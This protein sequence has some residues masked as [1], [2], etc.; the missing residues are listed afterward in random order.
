MPS[1]SSIPQYQYLGT[2]LSIFIPICLL[3]S[4][5]GGYFITNF[6]VSHKE[7]KQMEEYG[8]R[9]VKIIDTIFNKNYLIL[10]NLPLHNIKAC[11]Q[12]NIRYLE[13]VSSENYSI[14]NVGVVLPN[15]QLCHG[16]FFQLDLSLF[17]HSPDITYKDMSFW[18]GYFLPGMPRQLSAS[19]L[20]LK[21]HN[22]FTFTH[23]SEVEL[24]SSISQYAVQVQL[25]APKKK[26]IFSTGMMDTTP[27]MSGDSTYIQMKM[28]S[29]QWPYSI[30][31]SQMQAHVDKV[32]Q[33]TWVWVWVWVWGGLLIPGLLLCFIY[34][35]WLNA[36]LNSP[37]V[38]FK[39]AIQQNEIQ[40]YFQPIVDSRT[41]QCVGAEVLARWI[42]KQ[43]EEISPG[44]FIPLLEAQGLTSLLIKALLRQVVMDAQG[45]LHAR[46]A[47][48]V[49]FNVSIDDLQDKSV[50][51]LFQSVID[52]G[53]LLPSQLAIELTERKLIDNAM[54]LPL[55]T[56]YRDLGVKTL[57]D[58]F[59]TGASNIASLTTC[60]FDVLKI[61]KM[62]IDS[63]NTKHMTHTVT[64]R[65]VE[66]ANTF[67][68]TVIAEG[69]EEEEQVV[70]L[71]KMGVFWIQGWVYSPALPFS[72]WKS[73]CQRDK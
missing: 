25:T 61:D 4:G 23:L 51:R 1:L 44:V 64:K 71:Q 36:Y 14:E 56:Q 57:I 22:T 63:L 67:S 17:S 68:L 38:R 24:I 39:R 45:F 47:Y 18:S 21:Y 6:W 8:I 59:G 58:D 12:G 72:Q 34:G 42:P 33:T 60:P 19:F 11:E 65:I 13:L 2:I 69:V 43:G 9:I 15:G 32:V 55:L 53:K 28:L 73:F 26:T 62:F 46:P 52:T 27:L 40:P 20:V 50:L 37:K 49:S 16:Q 48:Y 5:V 7:Q 35:G 3:L 66:L 41:S 70:T 31:I 54:L 29:S 10:R 30:T